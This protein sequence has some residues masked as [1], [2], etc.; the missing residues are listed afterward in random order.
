MIERAK[1]AAVVAYK[2]RIRTRL[3]VTGEY[4]SVADGV[5]VGGPY[6]RRWLDTL[7]PWWTPYDNPMWGT[8]DEYESEAVAALR[9]T[10]TAGDTVVVV[11]GG[12]GVTAAVSADRVGPDGEVI[13]YEGSPRMA[14]IAS[15]TLAVNGVADRTTVQQAVVGPA[16]KVAGDTDGVTRH[17]PDSL[18]ACD[19]L[20]LDC[21]G[22]ETAVI[23]GLEIR[24]RAIVVE[25][26]GHLGS[27]EATVRAALSDRG[28][29]V[30]ARRAQ[31]ES[32]EIIVLTAV[33]EDAPSDETAAAERA[34]EATE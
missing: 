17:D 20:E 27:D 1:T 5:R 26:H 19:V 16:V 4:P 22:A 25:T 30:T 23:R 34:T 6:E 28:Y 2:D 9:E 24:P 8:W 7:V 32:R 14:G 21:E 11:G 13:V 15:E 3:P 12:R 33:R 18:P 10:V 29:R 31:D